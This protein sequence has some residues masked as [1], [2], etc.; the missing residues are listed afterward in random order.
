MIAGRGT[1]LKDPP[2]NFSESTYLPRSPG[3]LQ[4]DAF[5][6]M[7]NMGRISVRPISRGFG[8]RSLIRKKE[9][10]RSDIFVAPRFVGNTNRGEYPY[11]ISHPFVLQIGNSISTSFFPRPLR[12]R[13]PAGGIS[14]RRLAMT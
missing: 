2:A 5:P 11:Q 8:W 1:K 7:C 12:K 13:P 9:N 10:A 6:K 3:G 14:Y 4:A